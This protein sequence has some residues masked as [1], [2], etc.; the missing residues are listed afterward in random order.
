MT[1]DSIVF[2]KDQVKIKNQKLLKIIIKNNDGHS[3]S[4]LIPWEQIE[5][6]SQLAAEMEGQ[7]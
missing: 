4:V 2:Q 5:R 7:I 1:S 3:A 6:G